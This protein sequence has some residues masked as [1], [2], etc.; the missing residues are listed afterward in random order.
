LQI[1]LK[2]IIFLWRKSLVVDQLVDH[3]YERKNAQTENQE[4]RKKKRK[5]KE[6]QTIA[7]ENECLGTVY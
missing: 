1:L 6:N 2:D 5:G 4:G 7:I 3:Y